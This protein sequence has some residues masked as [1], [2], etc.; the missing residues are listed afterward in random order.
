MTTLFTSWRAPAA[1]AVI[2]LL[3][4]LTLPQR[5]N[6]PVTTIVAVLAAL[7]ALA[8]MVLTRAAPEKKI[9]LD[10]AVERTVSPRRSAR[11]LGALVLHLSP[12]ILLTAAFPLA[13]T[14]F[15]S[16]TVGGAPLGELLLASSVTVP[17]LSQAAAMPIYRGV[18]H[19]INNVPLPV[20]RGAFSE[21]WVVTF[22]Q[23]LVL[24][25]VFAVPMQLLMSWSLTTTA[26]Y[27]LLCALH[28]AFAQ[29]L[30]VSNIGRLRWAWASA[31]AG[32][33]L[34]LLVAPTLWFLPP[35]LGIL[36]QLV[37][38]RREL[39]LVRRLRSVDVRD[40]AADLLRG[41]LLGSVLW[42][43][44][45]MLFV[46]TDGRF[47]VQLVFAALMPA[48]VAYNYYFV[49]LAPWMDNAVSGIRTSLESRP[50]REL[51]HPSRQVVRSVVVALSRTAL[52]G[53]LLVLTTVALA[54]RVAPDDV[55]L[56]TAVAG[57]SFMFMMVTV[58]TYLLDYIGEK[59]AAQVVG[60]LH[61][62]FV[63]T[64]FTAFS[65]ATVYSTLFGLELLLL[66]GAL[67]VTLRHWSAPAYTL[68]WRHALTW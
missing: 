63:L 65:G 6:E 21:L 14:R 3:A 7:M 43:D 64:A 58:L 61:I 29:S 23:S 45:L 5:S 59:S 38:L 12:V 24:V 13:V 49:R 11:S 36:T 34:A 15:A 9:H 42:A 26:A 47:A 67:W 10:P 55:V 30:V 41:L 57:A 62:V 52:V 25:P 48:V 50:T 51:H 33:A 1:I 16:E 53:S 35:V 56:V 68:F 18:G 54:H 4:G 37:V 39:G 66:A 44:K 32:Y 2:V 8:V 46:V 19:L 17:W 20:I 22:L 40:A 28:I 27:A 60:V 31:W